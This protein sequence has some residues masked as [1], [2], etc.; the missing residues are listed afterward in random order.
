MRGMQVDSESQVYDNT[1]I[2]KHKKYSAP[3]TKT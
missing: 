2:M 1:K 3:D